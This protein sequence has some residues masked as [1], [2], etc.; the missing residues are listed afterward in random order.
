MVF[1]IEPGI[2]LPASSGFTG[3]D[4]H[5]KG[6]RPEILSELPVPRSSPRHE[7][8]RRP[9]FEERDAADVAADLCLR[10][11]PVNRGR[12]RIAAR[13][14]LLQGARPDAVELCRGRR[15]PSPPGIL[16]NRAPRASTWPARH[17]RS[18]GFQGR[19]RPR[20][21]GGNW[22]NL[23]HWLNSC[24]SSS[25]SASDNA[26]AIAPLRELGIVVEAKPLPIYSRPP[27][28]SS[29]AHGRRHP[30]HASQL[31][32]RSVAVPTAAS[33]NLLLRDVVKDA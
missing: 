15:R 10:V 4:R 28:R 3:R 20:R 23:R 30:G 12:S 18:S 8:H 1:S 13:V 14:R 5:P 27:L 2:Y 6:R 33:R 29:S 22:S 19:R 11:G 24:G 16:T 9:P 17:R 31:R 7:R 32:A 26:P 25:A 21:A